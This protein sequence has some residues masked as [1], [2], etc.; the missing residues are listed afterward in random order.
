MDYDEAISA[1]FAKAGG[2]PTAF[3]PFMRAVM[4]GMLPYCRRG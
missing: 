2:D 4:K 3:T 1:A